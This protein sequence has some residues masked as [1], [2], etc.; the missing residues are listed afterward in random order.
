MDENSL[1]ISEKILIVLHNY[2]A[3]DRGRSKKSDELAQI[4]QV[5]VGEINPILEKQAAEGY[6]TSFIDEQQ[7]RRHYLTRVGIIRVCSFFS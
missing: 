5:D 6:V 4:L 2:G 1:Q 7:N 3:V